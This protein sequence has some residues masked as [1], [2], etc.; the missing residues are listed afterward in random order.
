MAESSTAGTVSGGVEGSIFKACC[1]LRRMI[2]M[3]ASVKWHGF[4]NEGRQ[5]DAG[6]ND[7]N[8]FRS[9]HPRCLGRFNREGFSVIFLFLTKDDV[10]EVSPFQTIHCLSC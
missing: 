9:T 2:A 6:A 3:I 7:A 10:T 8:C 1:T 5:Q 4:W